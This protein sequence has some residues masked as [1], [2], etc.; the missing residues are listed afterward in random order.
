MLDTLWQFQME[1][2][3]E[4]YTGCNYNLNNETSHRL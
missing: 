1:D 3:K 2:K 4:Q